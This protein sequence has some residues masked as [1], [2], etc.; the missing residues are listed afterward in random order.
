MITLSNNP[1]GFVQYYETDK[2]P[3]GI[4]SKEPL[5]TVGIDY[6]IGEEAF[7]HKGFGSTIIKNTVVLIRK[8][9]KYEYIVADPDLKNIASVTVLV[10]N[11]FIKQ[12]NGLYK[13]KLKYL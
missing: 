4:W 3:V 5:G 9:E 12:K 8:T 7:L 1:I 2:A 10:N 13:L 6:L 11:G